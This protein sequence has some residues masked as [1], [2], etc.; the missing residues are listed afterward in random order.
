M[1]QGTGK[2]N[3]KY[4]TCKK[5][6]GFL[7]LFTAMLIFILCLFVKMEATAEEAAPPLDIIMNLSAELYKGDKIK[8]DIKGM[9]SAAVTAE[10]S[11]KK[12]ATV[13]EK[14]KVSALKCG[15]T[16]INISL[17][18]PNYTKRV[19]INL[20]VTRCSYRSKK[21]LLMYKGDKADISVSSTC[22]GAVVLVES[23]D[24]KAANIKGGKLIA[25]A[26][27]KTV[28]TASAE[29][30]G[31]KAEIAL[32]L[33]VSEKPKLKVTD[34]MKDDWFK[35]SIMAGHSVGLG[36]QSYCRAQ[37]NGFL[38][39]ARHISVGCYGVYN[40]MAPISGSSLH[41]T[42]NGRKARLKDHVKALGAKKVFIN[43]GLN[44]IGVF[45]PDRFIKSYESLV[46][47]L[48]KQNKNTTAYIVSPTPMYRPNGSLNN[49]NMRIINKALAKYSKKT[50][51]V[52]FIDVFTP[53]LDGTGKLNGAYC[54]DGYCH[55]TFAGYKVYSDA[56]KE[57]AAKKIVEE[58]DKKDKLY[59][60][61]ETAKTS[62]E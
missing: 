1:K 17:V 49:A 61:K 44:D 26:K 38:G 41:P 42:I 27:G 39:N 31:E 46:N 36:F 14:G 24:K 33:K 62:G 51:R 58:T 23:S 16:Q 21:K 35:G 10:S 45:G 5:M 9:E 59:T 29:T 18:Y 48:V 37:Y 13:D 60:K 2:M 43:Y 22:P 30:G 55:I 4:K 28:L 53:M 25:G 15:K 32:S 40:D 3:K 6:T 19:I 11:N 56:L 50:E 54:S 57:F 34:K 8:L 20:R 7:S 47:E 12:V 52:E